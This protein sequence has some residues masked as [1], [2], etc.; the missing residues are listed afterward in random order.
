MKVLHLDSALHRNPPREVKKSFD[1]FATN[2]LRVRAA[3]FRPLLFM[4]CLDVSFN[5]LR[6][7]MDMSQFLNIFLR[8]I[9]CGMPLFVRT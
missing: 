4:A 7:S 3:R 6:L 2:S 8:L 9:E 1:R 5:L